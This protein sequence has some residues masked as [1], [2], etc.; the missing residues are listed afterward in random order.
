MPTPTPS[1]ARA[2]TLHDK[3]MAFH[4]VNSAAEAII[5][6]RGRITPPSERDAKAK[7]LVARAEAALAKTGAAS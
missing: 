6:V 1:P 7:A 3:I 4:A 2:A 5:D